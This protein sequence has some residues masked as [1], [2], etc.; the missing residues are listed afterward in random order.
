VS[1][2]RRFGQR[3]DLVLQPEGAAS[4]ANEIEKSDA[5][6]EADNGRPDFERKIHN[7]QVEEER[8]AVTKQRDEDHELPVCVDYA[9]ANYRQV[10]L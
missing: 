10:D 1:L 3:G 5:Y 4:D 6:Y 9:E 8:N 7:P 2:S